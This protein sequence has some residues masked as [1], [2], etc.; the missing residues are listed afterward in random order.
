MDKSQFDS[1]VDSGFLSGS[2][3][4]S[5]S[6]LCDEPHSPA[7]AP[8]RSPRRDEDDGK[9][10]LSSPLDSGIDISEQMSSLRLASSSDL[11]DSRPPPSEAPRTTSPPRPKWEPSTR[12][13]GLSEE[14]IELLREIF[15]RDEDGD[16]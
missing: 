6:S 8:S 3:L 4:L 15:K 1:N 5:S 7:V 11:S 2:N 13:F 9:T 12:W 16:T 10:L 14:Q